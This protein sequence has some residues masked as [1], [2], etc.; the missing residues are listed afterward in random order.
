MRFLKLDIA[1]VLRYLMR[2]ET[3]TEQHVSNIYSIQ[4]G[5]EGASLSVSDA[6][7]YVI[8]RKLVFLLSA[9]FW[10]AL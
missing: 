5:N 6:D 9:Y 8:D 7:R 1:S 10:Y 3:I 4:Y 2:N